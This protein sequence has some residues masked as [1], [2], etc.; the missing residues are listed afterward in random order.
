MKFESAYTFF[1]LYSVK[2]L[3]F[4]AGMELDGLPK[5][6]SFKIDKVVFVFMAPLS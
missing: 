5:A 2:I 6:N 4:V 1:F 3:S